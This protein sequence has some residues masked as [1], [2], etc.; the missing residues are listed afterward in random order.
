MKIAT[1]N[2]NSVRLRMPL[3]KKLA[4][5]HAPDILCLQETK[6]TDELFPESDLDKLGFKHRF[7]SGQ[8][9]YN[10]VAIL[11][12]LPLKDREV[13]DEFGGGIHRRHIA[14]TLPDGTRLH[15][16][17]VPAGGDIPDP[18]ANPKFADKLRCVAEMTTWSK[19]VKPASKTIIMGD[20]NIAPHEHDVWS[21]KQ[22][23]DVVSHTPVETEGLLA[24][25]GI[26][27]WI[28][29]AR[30][31]VPLE[32]KLYSWWSYRNQDWKK[33]DRGRRLDHIWIT[34]GL[35]DALVSCHTLRDARDWI[36]PSDHVPVMVEVNL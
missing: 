10:G 18:V 27:K 25:K 36:S 30:E 35:K 22:L 21:H 17:Y 24:F 6:V 29:I 14:A 23:L 11:S 2:I 4:K 8:K 3:V 16:F 19:D 26:S 13:I 9:S 32:Q 34:P 15:N 1:W 7:F 20:F 33:S 28:D 31:Y 12:K 5:E